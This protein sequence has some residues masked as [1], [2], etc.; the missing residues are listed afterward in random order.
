M[1]WWKQLKGMPVVSVAEGRELGKVETLLVDVETGT[2]KWVQLARRSF[3]GKRRIVS[4]AVVGAIVENAIT[5][6]SEESVRRLEEVPEARELSRD[7]RRIIGN[8]VLTNKGRLLGQ[9][10]DYEF[11][12]D[13]FQIVRYE[14]GK[15]DLLGTRSRLA[16]A[17]HVLTIG[18][19]AVL[20]DAAIESD[21][22]IEESE[23]L[24][25]TGEP[26]ETDDVEESQILG[27]E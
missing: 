2:V 12:E 19:D 23:L 5:V 3:L 24:G 21:L 7:R 15:G 13:T 1:A 17:E 9:I 11:D 20:V 6:D 8:R 27:T 26:G 16:Y 10:R 25:E 18:P 14:I 4:M 22:T